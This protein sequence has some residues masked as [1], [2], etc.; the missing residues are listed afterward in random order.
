MN[1]ADSARLEAFLRRSARLGFRS[2][3]APTFASLCAEADDRLFSNILKDSRHLLQPLLPPTRDE[4]Y[5]LRKRAHNRQLPVRTSSINDNGFLIRM[6]Y[7]NVL[8]SV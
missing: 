6:L 2:V 1:A 4:H 3:S 8:N 7:K 5:N